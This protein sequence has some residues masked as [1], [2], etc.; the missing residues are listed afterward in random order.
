MLNTER[1]EPSLD[2]IEKH[3]PF[4]QELD[5]SDFHQKIKKL[6]DNPE[7]L[8]RK[9]SFYDA[10][11]F[12]LSFEREKETHKMTT[13]E[14]QETLIEELQLFESE[15]EKLNSYPG[16][17]VANH[18]FLIG[19]NDDDDEPRLY[20]VVD[21]IDGENLLMTENIE[22]SPEAKRSVDEFF[23]SMVHYWEDVYKEKR[24]YMWDI[25]PRQIVYGTMPGDTEK[26][27]YLID[28]DPTLNPPDDRL[29]EKLT[30]LNDF[31]ESV[32]QKF[33]PPTKLEKA[34]AALKNAALLLLENKS[35]EEISMNWPL[36]SLR[37]KILTE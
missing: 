37:T 9:I 3:P 22:P 2:D 19:H 12:Y 31:L 17:E 29:P 35:E 13:E 33:D 36:D 25:A 30:S 7:K 32:E 10:L 15:L 16:I 23:T 27:V 18:S 20:T 24:I 11:Q 26:K 34:R 6:R 1:M 5:D 21:R 28:L 4:L 14:R 8:V